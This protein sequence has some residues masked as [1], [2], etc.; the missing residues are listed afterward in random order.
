MSTKYTKVH[1]W[2]KLSGDVASAGISDYIK[3]DA[4]TVS[5]MF[6]PKAKFTQ[7]FF[8]NQAEMIASSWKVTQMVQLLANQAKLSLLTSKSV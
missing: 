8:A 5:D 4:A 2:A 1:E 6:T 7:T 3:T